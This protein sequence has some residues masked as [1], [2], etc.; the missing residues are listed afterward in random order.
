MSAPHL[1]P[2]ELGEI[3]DGA[4]KIYRAR[5]LPMFTLGVLPYAGA[6]LLVAL[7]APDRSDP[8]IL[9]LSLMV[10]GLMAEGFLVSWGGV[11]NVASEA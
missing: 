7:P 8:A 11:A 2:L 10:V 6:M 3:L 1:R 9:A 4:F 5:F